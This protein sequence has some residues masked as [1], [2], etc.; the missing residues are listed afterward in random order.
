MNTLIEIGYM[1][2]VLSA[3]KILMTYKSTKKETKSGPAIAQATNRWFSTTAALV[4]VQVMP[5]GI[6]GEKWH[7]GSLQ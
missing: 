1:L 2:Q 7:W 6:Y 3:F 5:Y 4:L